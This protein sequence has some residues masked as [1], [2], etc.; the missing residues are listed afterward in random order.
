MLL[1]IFYKDLRESG[2]SSIVVGHE[3]GDG[4]DGAFAQ[5]DEF[6]DVRCHIDDSRRLWCDETAIND[7]IE[8][9]ESMC[10]MLGVAELHVFR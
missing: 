10:D 9:W 5:S 2:G 6:G 7:T 3:I 8:E 4:I 1:P